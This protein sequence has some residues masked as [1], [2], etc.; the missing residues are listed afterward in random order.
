MNSSSRQGSPG[1]M[2]S[3]IVLSGKCNLHRSYYVGYIAAIPVSILTVHGHYIS[4]ELFKS[5]FSCSDVDSFIYFLCLG[6]VHNS[7]I[8]LHPVYFMPFRTTH[9]ALSPCIAHAAII[10]RMS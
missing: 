9:H 6:H 8:S 10:Q 7:I 4:A 3:D 1:V 5:A 2:Q